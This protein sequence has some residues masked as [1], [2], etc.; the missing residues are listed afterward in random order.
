MPVDPGW[1]CSGTSVPP[2]PLIVLGKTKEWY[3]TWGGWGYYWAVSKQL[4]GG[5]ECRSTFL[6]HIQFGGKRI[7]VT[8]DIIGGRGVVGNYGW[9]S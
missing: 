7:G 2:H 6:R 3:L 4:C 8:L 1:V 5:E 9:G